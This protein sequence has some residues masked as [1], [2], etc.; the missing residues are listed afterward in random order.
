[1]KAILSP[2]AVEALET[3][4]SEVQK[5]FYKQIRLLEA[6]VRHP[7]LRAKKFDAAGTFWQ[8]RVDRSW[9]F[10]FV[11]V[12]DAYRILDVIPHPK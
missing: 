9:R 7:S 2:R 11:V 5:A 1:M 3:A 6:N 8:A 10:Y 12:N 4:P